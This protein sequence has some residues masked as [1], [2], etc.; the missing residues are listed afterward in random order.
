M[1]VGMQIFPQV[2]LDGL[3]VGFLYA[4][5]ALGYTMVYG[6]LEFINFAHS[7]IFMIG[8][9][10][11]AEVLLFMRGLGLL[12]T[13]PDWVPLILALV[14]AISVAGLVGVTIERLAYRPV[15]RAPK[16]VSL[17]TAIGVSFF[18]QDLVRIVWSFFRGNYVLGVPSLFKG[19]AS[20]TLGHTADGDPVNLS[21][22]YTALLIMGVALIM[23]IA[24]TQFI[25]RT[26]LGKAMRAVAQ[27]RTTAALMGINVDR[28]ISL[29]FLIGGAL[30]GA[31]GTLFAVRYGNINPYI[32]FVLGIKAFTAAVFGGIGNLAGAMTGGIILGVLESLS[33]AYLSVATNGAL[34]GAEYKDIFSFMLLI[35]IMIFK[36]AGLLGKS[37]GEKV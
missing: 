26:R 18:L 36:P 2:L 37:Y 24:L 7:E 16:L 13:L 6:V 31:A 27:D 25:T 3:I 35:T 30:G 21:I 32:G 34:N 28:I 10:V 4:V 15:R 5:V 20:T 11:G 1:Q 12:G 17:I 8:A 14:A 33:A 19:N 22:P 29:T 23:M 9:F